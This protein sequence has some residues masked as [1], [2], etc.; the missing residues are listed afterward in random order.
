M[1]K[2][3]ARF[4][5]LLLVLLSI[6]AFDLHAL[7]DHVQSNSNRPI[8]ASGWPA[9]SAAPV[10]ARS[11]SSSQPARF[12]K[13]RVGI[14]VKNGL[15]V[16]KGAA[17]PLNT[18]TT[19]GS[20]SGSSPFDNP[21]GRV[22]MKVQLKMLERNDESNPMMV[23]VRRSMPYI[24]VTDSLIDPLLLTSFPSN[25]SFTRDTSTG[26]HPSSLPF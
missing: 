14:V 22:G 19:G 13:P 23:S 18:V 4:L 21:D 8:R 10:Y 1:K 26:H 7:I 3:S 20:E 12:K 17:A 24:S 2:F 5:T 9:A 25:N 6:G 15:A 16:T 11:E